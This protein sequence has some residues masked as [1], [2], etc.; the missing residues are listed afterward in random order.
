MSSGGKSGG[1]SNGA[2]DYYGTIAGVVAC[3][4]LDFIGG[5]VVDD[6]LV[7]PSAPEWPAGTR[8]VSSKRITPH[9]DSLSVQTQDPHGC[10]TGDHVSLTGFPQPQMNVDYGLVIQAND[11]WGL[12]VA[13]PGVGPGQ[14]TDYADGFVARVTPI[15]V[16]EL[17]R[18]GAL[19]YQCVTAHQATP[20]T[21]PPNPAFWRQYRLSRT[22]T[23]V[24]NPLILSETD[25]GPAGSPL[26]KLTVESRG[27]LF[28]YWGTSDQTL[29]TLHENA[30]AGLGHPP[31]RDQAVVVLKDFFFGRER[32]T[33]PNVQIIA[34]RIPQQT[35]ITGPSAGLDAE[36]Q[37]NPFCV[38]AELLTHPLWGLGFPPEQL[39][40]PS[41]QAA[42][43]WAATAPGLL[44]LSPL[45]DRQT[46]GR[47]VI[48]DLLA[49]VDGWL[50]WNA[51]GML[52][53]GHWPH[54]EGPPAFDT[55]NTV[56]EDSAVLDR[57]LQWM[58]DGWTGT[59]NKTTIIYPDAAHGFKDRPA[60]ASNLW[61]RI[62]RG[63]VANRSI[64]RPHVTR[65]AQALA[66]AAR[67]VQLNADWSV[68]GSMSVR[69][70]TTRVR[71]GDPL[72]VVHALL[73]W[74][75]VA[76]CT[77]RTVA[78][79]PSA[80]VTL[81]VETER[82]FALPGNAPLPTPP[83][84]GGAPR[85]A[86]VTRFA[87]VQV[88]PSLAGGGDFQLTLLAAR[89]SRLTS[90][91]QIWMRQADAAAF[92][93]LAVLTRFAVGGTVQSDFAPFR[94]GAGSLV[95]DDDTQGINL[96]LDDRTPD[97][98]RDHLLTVPTA[99]AI[100]DDSLLL[101]LIPV[102]ADR[103]SAIE[104][105]TVKAVSTT[106]LSQYRIV[107]RRAG[108]GTEQGGDGVSSWRTGDVGWL[109]YRS[110]LLTFTHGQIPALSLAGTPITFR[111]VPASDWVEGDINDLYQSGSANGGL[112]V[113][114][115]F[116]PTD[117]YAPE[118]RWISLVRAGMP[119]DFGQTYAIG[120]RFD[121]TLW[122]G[123]PQGSLVSAEF[124]ATLGSTALVW[125]I[126]GMAGVTGG[127]RTVGLDGLGLGDWRLG[128]LLR[129]AAGRTLNA[130]WPDGTGDAVLKIRSGTPGVIPSPAATPGGGNHATYPL[131]ITLTTSV[132]GG[133][134]QYWITAIGEVPTGAPWSY[135]NP[136]VMIANQTLWAQTQAPDST[137][138]DRIS[139]DFT[140]APRGVRYQVP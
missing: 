41:W 115:T 94:S 66:L 98:D 82:G 36:G 92:Y 35:V 129:N 73:G 22:D 136:V 9:T 127:L 6:A 119:V 29:D 131:S 49:H 110:E 89:S 26:I 30:L 55:G 21:A 106:G 57:E 76:R 24:A 2:L 132:A 16:H 45:L 70:E 42:A 78:A 28:L 10:S 23:G 84:P 90:R 95:D 138:S 18:T 85:P 118:V 13:T 140:Q 1:G 64:E 96:Q 37:A 91:L 44:Y 62:A 34:G 33:P 59:I 97:A 101:I 124:I 65:A 99:D 75:W 15:G 74:Q 56:N 67:D 5:V 117:P 109:F 20:D 87:F 114:T 54:G 32:A 60:V 80:R 108:F 50:R 88:P 104:V 133:V 43:D 8:S 105:C 79:L 19:V 61:N 12:L 77:E 130:H 46:G 68:R 39:D 4:P 40:V 126:S 14:T 38:L 25:P 58:G 125:P 83:G 51:A 113:E 48:S 3:G 122:V 71:P 31:Y 27:E 72:R 135:T 107:V 86:P 112:T 116:I 134:I 11:A 120:D 47:Q 121:A 128:V 93:E 52:E 81:E 100:N 123:D 111:L 69:A 7:W 103:N 137:L 102:A 53:A 139:F 63:R 17:R